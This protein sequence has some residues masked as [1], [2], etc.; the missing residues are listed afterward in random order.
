MRK[1]NIKDTYI[2]EYD[3]WSGILEAVSF[4]F[5]STSNKLKV[6]ILGEL[7]FG[8]D[9]ILLIKYTSDLE[10]IHQQKQVKMNKDEI[11]ENSKIV[12]HNYKVRYKVVLNNNTAFKYETP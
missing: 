9:M 12:D 3:P 11:R 4:V 1:Y 7:L 10:L 5:C 2:G 6:Y 8:H